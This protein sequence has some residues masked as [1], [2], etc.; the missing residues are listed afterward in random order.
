MYRGLDLDEQRQLFSNLAQHILTLFSHRFNA[1]GSLFSS[2][3]PAIPPSVPQ[4]PLESRPGTPRP[5]LQPQSS[6]PFPRPAGPQRA[7]GTDGGLPRSR[8]QS[9]VTPAASFTVGPI[10]SWPF[11]GEGR[12]VQDLDRGP[13]STLEAYLRA[14]CDREI[15]AVQ[16]ECEGRAASHRP[17]LPPEEGHSAPSS[18]DEEDSDDGEVYYR[19]YR[20]RQR[21]SLLVAHAHAR[22]GVVRQEMERFLKYMRDLGCGSLKRDQLDAFSFDLHDLSLD[23]IFVDESDHTTIVSCNSFEYSRV[24]VPY[25]GVQTSII[26]WESTCI[27]P[28]WQCA[29][30]PA[31]L[32]AHPHSHEADMFREEMGKLG[33]LGA[34]WLRGES[35]RAEWRRA[36]KVLEWDGW[37]EGLIYQTLDLDE[38]SDTPSS[39]GHV[40]TGLLRLL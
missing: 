38:E 29:H 27:R 24:S 14:C 35:E 10:V 31:F 32:A 3:N 15:D 33:P 18:S 13:W 5:G 34:L 28:L 19:D 8:S 12:G 9:S 37:E 26:D 30:L 6:Y 16:K 2:V 7:D 40:G 4:T 17:H 36:H 21:T 1:V 25:Y 39:S 20:T 23:N 11:F 22:V